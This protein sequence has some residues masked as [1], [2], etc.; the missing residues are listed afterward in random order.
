MILSC[1][2]K[3][4]TLVVLD[5]GQSISV[6]MCWISS[7]VKTILNSRQKF[8]NDFVKTTQTKQNCHNNL[9]SIVRIQHVVTQI[10]CPKPWATSIIRL[11]RVGV[12][13]SN[14]VSI[15]LGKCD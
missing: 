3:K 14:L 15:S 2:V 4:L 5:L 9:D 10:D 1:G 6:T 8:S 13:R 7:I 12:E 11:V